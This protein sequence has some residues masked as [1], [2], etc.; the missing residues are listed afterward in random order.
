MKVTVSSCL[1]LSCL[2]AY[3]QLKE[4]AP[5]ENTAVPVVENV[6]ASPARILGKIPDGTPPPVSPPKPKYN[7]AKRDILSTST[8]WQGGR[9]ITV[10]E[11]KPIALPQP[12][13]PLETAAT[14]AD[15]EFIERLK[16]WHKAHP[17][18]KM[19]FLGATVFRSHY[20]PPRTLVRYWPMGKEGITFWSSADFSLIAGGIGSFADSTGAVHSLFMSWSNM[21]AD[22]AARLQAAKGRVYRAPEIPA[23]TE[24]NATYQ[25]V[26]GQP[27]A[28]ELAVIQS[29]H[30]LYNSEFQRLKTAYDGREQ[31]RQQREA[32]LKA[33]PPQPKDITLNYWRTEKP[34]P[35]KGGAR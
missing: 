21:D 8:H 11:I 3:A 28:G 2:P 14:V 12:P 26:D 30:D 23:F 4:A 18:P 1:L 29:L 27:D 20:H 25:I 32:Y 22:R 24:G 15:A 35:A 13:A 7:V 5:P 6:P 17:S 34:A 10:R 31:A 33:N 16:A 9:T 19:L